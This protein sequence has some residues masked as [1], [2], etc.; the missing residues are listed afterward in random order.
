MKKI[1]LV[2]FLLMGLL[3]LGVVSSCNKATQTDYPYKP[4][5]F[6]DVKFSDNFWS[7]RLETNR[8]VTIP[9]AFEQCEETGRVDNFE[10]A[11]KVKTR[12]AERGTFS[13]VYPFDDSDVFKIIEGASYALKIQPDPELDAYLDSLISK[14]AAAQEEDGYL[15]TARTINADP[16][17]RWT[18]GERWSNLYMGHEL[19]NVGHLYEAAVAHYLATGKRS[20]LDVALKNADLIVSVFGPGRKHGAP[21]CQEIEIGLVKLYRVTGEKK[22]LDLANFFLDER[23]NAKDRKLYGEY[24][25]DHKPILD[26]DEAV[27]HAVRACYMYSGIADVA[28]LTGNIEYIRMVDRVWENVVA[29]KMYITGGIGS[30]GRREAFG[31]NYDLPNAT[32]YSETCAS[33]SN[34]LWNHRMFLLHGDAKYIDVLERVLYNGI[35]SGIALSGELFFYSNPLESFGKDKR[36]PWFSCAC[37]PSNVSRFMP[38]IP[39][40]VYALKEDDLFVNLFVDGETEIVLGVTVVHVEQETGY[41]WDGNVKIT[42]NP[43]DTKEFTV[44]VRIPGWALNK[45]VP[46]DLYRFLETVEEKPLLKVNGKQISLSLDKGFVPIRRKWREGDVIELILPMPI[47]KV[48]SHP[49]VKDNMGKVA[50]QRGPIVYCAEWPDNQGNVSNL[51]LSDK[52]ELTAE[53]RDDLF[54]GVTVIRGMA[55]ALFTG[56]DGNEVRKEEQ[57]FI[58]IPYY[59]WAHR[60]EGEMSVWLPRTVSK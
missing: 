28:A 12:G 15:Y 22:Y 37:C 59:A 44:N 4:V 60:G 3:I 43:Q 41:P 38:S 5:A 58:A 9:Y 34:V 29:K 49:K 32:A 52:G 47:R 51:V 19:Y 54:R 45:P 8:R 11:K 39:G 56:S 20:L 21:G 31:P 36:R 50:L 13:T 35:L 48:L 27:G 26:Q 46:S 2:K 6:T 1:I 53:H 7:P 18:E 24:S 14:I 33:I 57:D 55:L 17:V 42:V 10:E 23:G 16:P 25:Q 40:Y 30:R